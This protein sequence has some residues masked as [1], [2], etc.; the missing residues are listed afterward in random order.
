M[1]LLD[2]CYIL[3]IFMVN[4]LK[5]CLNRARNNVRIEELRIVTENNKKKVIFFISVRIVE[6]DAIL[7][8]HMCRNWQSSTLIEKIF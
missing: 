3:F 8:W 1:I 6:Y 4:I 5:T 7:N 2:T